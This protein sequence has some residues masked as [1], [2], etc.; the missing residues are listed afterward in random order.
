MNAASSELAII[1][2]G[3]RNEWFVDGFA[4]AHVGS[5]NIFGEKLRTVRH[6]QDSFY[7]TDHQRSGG[8]EADH[9]HDGHSD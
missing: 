9:D 6:S 8:I 3:I 2:I 5:Q 4:I 1:L 7:E